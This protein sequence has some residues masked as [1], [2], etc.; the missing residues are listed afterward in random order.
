MIDTLSSS[1]FLKKPFLPL[2]CCLTKLSI[3]EK[4]EINN[5]KGNICFGSQFQR[6]L[7]TFAYPH[8]FGPVG[9]KATH[10]GKELVVEQ[11]C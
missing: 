6:F 8:F 5:L 9:R 3:M 2:N 4:N 11:S 1:F 10:H 7:S